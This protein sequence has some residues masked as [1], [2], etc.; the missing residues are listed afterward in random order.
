MAVEPQVQQFIDF[1]RD[2]MP[3]RIKTNPNNLPNAKKIS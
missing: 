3:R 1:I 2:E